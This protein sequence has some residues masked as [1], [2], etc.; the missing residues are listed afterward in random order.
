MYNFINEYI[1]GC[2]WNW[3]IVLNFYYY[4]LLCRLLFLNF[5]YYDQNKK[6]FQTQETAKTLWTR[7]QDFQVDAAFILYVLLLRRLPT[8]QVV[9][10][11]IFR[12]SSSQL[13]NNKTD[14]KILIPAN[15]PDPHPQEVINHLRLQDTDPIDSDCSATSLIELTRSEHWPPENTEHDRR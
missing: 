10:W 4:W 9:D 13:S 2:N 5:E 12:L 7:C 14:N 8:I 1:E 11:S 3:V 15:G 6:V